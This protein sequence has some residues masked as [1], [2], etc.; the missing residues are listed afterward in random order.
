MQTQKSGHA[1]PIFMDFSVR[2]MHNPVTAKRMVSMI[3]KE[4]QP[5][6][7]FIATLREPVIPF[8]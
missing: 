8:A 5:K 6:L 2:A 1:A 4:L 3:P 7:K